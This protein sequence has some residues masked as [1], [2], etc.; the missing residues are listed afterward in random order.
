MKTYGYCRVSTAE[1]NEARQLNALAALGIPP[2]HIYVDKQSGK[3]FTRPAW[4]AMVE[5]FNP[6]DL[7]YVHAI[8][9]LGRN[10]IE[11]QECW[12]ILTKEM[13]IDIAV[14]SMPLLDTRREK[15]LMGNFISDLVLQILSFVAQSERENIRTRQTE[16]IKAARQRGVKFGRPAKMLPDNFKKVVKQWERGS[17][18]IDEALKQ[19]GMKQTTFYARLKA[20]REGREG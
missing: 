4:Q 6:G 19:T 1:Q 14:L 15:D 3:D 2:A 10:Y 11:I 18:T 12:R 17:I 5:K 20:L 7:L 13:G 8:D 9:R 16:G